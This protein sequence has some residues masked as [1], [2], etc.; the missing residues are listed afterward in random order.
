MASSSASS[1]PQHQFSSLYAVKWGPFP[2]QPPRVFPHSVLGPYLS[3]VSKWRPLLP[4]TRL[5][6]VMDQLM[7]VKRLGGVQDFTIQQAT[8]EILYIASMFCEKWNQLPSL[9][10]QRSCTATTRN[11]H[12]RQFWTIAIA[13]MVLSGDRICY[14]EADEEGVTVHD[15]R[16]PKAYSGWAKVPSL[17][18]HL[19]SLPPL[20][21]P[22]KQQRSGEQSPEVGTPE[23]EAPSATG[24]LDK[25]QPPD[26]QHESG[27][28]GGFKTDTDDASLEMTLDDL[29]V[30]PELQCRPNEDMLWTILG[31]GLA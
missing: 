18:R 8:K 9:R 24:K 7:D 3:K 1:V 17:Y 4:T 22:Q 11:I 26:I 30:P 13:S 16:G 20:Q 12:V 25:P 23:R 28:T 21:P 27:F 6:D 19:Q 14:Y 10:I 31:T 2:Y 5:V 29:H 15:A